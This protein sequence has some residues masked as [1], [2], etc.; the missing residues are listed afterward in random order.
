MWTASA[1]EYQCTRAGQPC[2]GSGP[3][4]RA[5]G[6][7]DGVGASAAR[8]LPLSVR[9]LLHSGCGEG[10]YPAARS[11]SDSRERRGIIAAG[12]VVLY[13]TYT[14]PPFTHPLSPDPHT[15][16]RERPASQAMAQP[17]RST[18]RDQRP[19]RKALTNGWSGRARRDGPT[20]SSDASAAHTP[21]CTSHD[22][23]KIL[24][25]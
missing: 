6:D 19:G 24:P 11:V 10:L 20:A 1:G 15:R 12:E 21:L 5:V 23:S 17:S 25:V 7:S 18:P 4:L 16:C 2:W 3:R 14:P 8:R 9:P 22:I 13:S